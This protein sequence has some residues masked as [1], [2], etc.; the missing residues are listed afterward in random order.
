MDA[1]VLRGKDAASCCHE[2]GYPRRGLAEH[3]LCPECGVAPAK[4]N[5]TARGLPSV[6]ITQQ[7]QIR[8]V[9]IGLFLLLYAS[10]YS[11]QLALVMNYEQLSLHA[12]N[13]PSPKLAAVTLVQ[14]EIG[15]RPGPWGTMGWSCVLFQLVAVYLITVPSI[16]STANEAILSLRRTTRW[17][18]L[19]CISALM[20]FMLSHGQGYIPLLSWYT[21]DLLLYALVIGELPANLL[22]YLY[23]GKLASHYRMPRVAR[24]LKWL[25]WI[26]VGVRLTCV[27]VLVYPFPANQL[28]D[29]MQALVLASLACFAIPAG[30]VGWA[31]VLNLTIR[32]ARLG[33]TKPIRRSMAL[34][35]DRAPVIRSFMR[36]LEQH[37]HR[38]CVVTGLALWL[39]AVASQFE[40]AVN[41]SR[42]GLGGELPMLNYVGPKISA[43][44]LGANNSFYSWRFATTDVVSV[45]WILMVVFLIT[46]PLP[47]LNMADHRMRLTVRWGLV[48]GLG[49]RFGMLLSLVGPAM[50]DSYLNAAHTLLLEA[51]ATALMLWYL[52][53]VARTH[54]LP[55]MQCRLRQLA[56]ISSV[57][58]CSPLVLYY[59]SRHMW[60]F[61]ESWQIGVIGA[62]YCVVSM[63]VG[64]CGIRCIGLLSW[65]IAKPLWEREFPA[66]HRDI[67]ATI[68]IKTEAPT[69]E[70]V[71]A[72]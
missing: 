66:T 38:I 53:R 50:R 10:Y 20:G 55:S 62:A 44:W 35:K 26:G 68:P 22:L 71:G 12:I 13:L 43:A 7:G 21:W 17:T 49:L 39:L 64:V 32:S 65:Q 6:H 28:R 72:S 4:L 33:F 48:V 46:A 59:S 9:A 1:S 30:V 70:P 5:K 23:L 25:A 51:P 47:G 41:T 42:R 27:G 58:I 3:T 19:I 34:V 8:L 18:S 56:I 69:G 45:S 16:R 2:C 11:M 57:V 14:R 67:A 54:L 60:A 52:S 63:V 37:F 40:F 31:A 24:T 36:F 29:A 15:G 61:H